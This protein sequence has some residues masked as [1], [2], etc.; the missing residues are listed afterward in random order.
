MS[1][2]NKLLPCMLEVAVPI[3]QEQL[4]KQPWDTIN[5][6]VGEIAKTL[7]ERGDLLF[8]KSKK[9]GGTADVFNQTAEG[10]AILS[11]MPGGVTLFGQHWEAQHPGP[12]LST[13]PVGVDNAGG[14]EDGCNEKTAS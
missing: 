7:C 9:E 14:I 4:K 8:F 11:F 12:G 13:A 5:S 3:W 10:I 6:R 2:E 1:D